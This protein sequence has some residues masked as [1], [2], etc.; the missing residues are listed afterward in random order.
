MI[1]IYL[2]GQQQYWPELGI[3]MLLGSNLDKKP[4]N[5]QAIYFLPD[6]LM[7]G[8]DHAHTSTGPLVLKKENLLQFPE[9]KTHAAWITPF[10]VFGFLLLLSILLTLI[11]KEPAQKILAVFDIVLFSL[12]GLIGCIMLYVWL[13]RVD[14]VCRNNINI[15]WALPTHIFAVFF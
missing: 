8:F 15:V 5:E 1:H 10:S 4:S 3:D 7:K 9:T 6:Y 13:A 14:E 11:R 12:L 2:D